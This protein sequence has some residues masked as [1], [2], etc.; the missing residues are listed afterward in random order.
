MPYFVFLVPAGKGVTLLKTCAKFSE[1][2]DFCRAER[3]ARA[4]EA[5]AIRMAFAATD[6]EARRLLTDKRA[7]SSPLEDWEA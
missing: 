7:P 5:D 1:A 6:P 4:A 2:R 3:R